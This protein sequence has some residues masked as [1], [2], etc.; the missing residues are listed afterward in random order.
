MTGDYCKI[1][2]ECDYCKCKQ[3]CA[4]FNF[5]VAP[6]VLS[7]YFSNLFCRT[8]EQTIC[9]KWKRKTVQIM[10]E[11]HDLLDIFRV[12]GQTA[13]N[14]ENAFSSHPTMCW[15]GAFLVV[16]LWCNF[17]P[18]LRATLWFSLGGECLG[19]LAKIP[20][21]HRTNNLSLFVDKCFNVSNKIETNIWG[22]FFSF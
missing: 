17:G 5:L 1:F 12:A 21:L 6:V 7:L 8:A 19:A 11:L 13:F 22:V 2:L 14:L 3:R 15:W 16:Q 9:Q 10:S 20:F 4:F 18:V